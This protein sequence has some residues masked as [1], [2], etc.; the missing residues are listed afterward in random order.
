MT[1]SIDNEFGGTALIADP[2]H[3]YIQFTVT[4]RKGEDRFT[5]GAAAALYLSTTKRALGLPVGGA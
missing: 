5:V 1:Q 3:R 2:I 4:E